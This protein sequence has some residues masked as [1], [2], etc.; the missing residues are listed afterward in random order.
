M[1]TYCILQKSLDK[2]LIVTETGFS[3][4]AFFLGPIW[5]L[6]RKLWL[7]SAI[8]IAFLIYCNFILSIYDLKYFF[9]L[10]SIASSLFWGKFA[11]DLYIQRLINRKFKPLKHVVANSKEE[12]IIQFLT[13]SN[14]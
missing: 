13:E 14:K 12:A 4:L 2:D 5:G 1:I 9:V 7:Y 11:R 8:G 3:I 10:S 6:F